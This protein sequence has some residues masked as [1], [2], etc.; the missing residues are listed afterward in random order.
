MLNAMKTDLSEL[1]HLSKDALH[2]HIGIGLY[3]IAMLALRRGPG[4]WWPWL[5]VLGFA[6]LNEAIDLYHNGISH[7][8]L[9]GS[10]KD[11]INTMVWPTAIVVFARI[12]SRRSPRPATGSDAQTANQ[13]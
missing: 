2:I 12:H 6:L 13:T 5:T 10:L 7:P 9:S 11:M 1:L 3:V 4:S 8:E